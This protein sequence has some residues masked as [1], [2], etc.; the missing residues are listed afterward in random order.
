MLRI[1]I[2]LTKSD[3]TNSL[4]SFQL[5]KF[6]DIK[7]YSQS[8]KSCWS[9]NKLTS[10]SG[11]FFCE[12]CQSLL[13]IDQKIDFFQLFGLETKHQLDATELTKKFRNLQS[14]L[15]PDKFSNRSD[16]EQSLSLEWSSLINKA[17]KTLQ[18]PLQRGEYILKLKGIELPEGNTDLD[19][20][21]LMEIM[22]KNEQVEDAESKDDL[23]TI[24]KQ[25]RDEILQLSVQFSEQLKTDNIE[26]AKDHLVKMKYLT[27]IEN[28][29]KEKILV[30]K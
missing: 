2:F 29:I 22:E 10:K 14:Q 5:H 3:K 4:R 30:V 9:C 6:Q 18:T 1:L 25:T 26:K 28:S 13:Q 17:Y 15:H 12:S 21:F 20:E 8:T 16:K 19:K 11:Q 7:R 24:L 27:S 23:K